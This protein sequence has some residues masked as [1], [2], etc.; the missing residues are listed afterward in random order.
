VVQVAGSSS[1][2]LTLSTA[3]VAA[4]SP[5]TLTGTVTGSSSIG[6]PVGSVD[7]YDGVNF[8]GTGVLNGSGIATFTT[9]TVPVGVHPI[10]ANY[11]GEARYLSSR[12]AAQTLTVTATGTATTL[13]SSVNP[14][15]VGQ[16]VVLTAVVA[17][18][19]GSGVPTG[20][21][22]FSEA[23]TSL[24][25]GTV[26]TTGKATLSISTLAGG[27]HAVIATYAGDANY[28]GSASA[29]LT[30]TV[31]V[32]AVAFSIS[33]TSLTIVH[34]ASGTAT[35]S[36]TPSGGFSGTATFACG[37]LPVDASCSFSP[38]SMA[39]T[40]G[41]AV[42]TTTLTIST[43]LTTGGALR[44]F[45][46]R[47]SGGGRVLALL[48]MPWL[49]L[50]G[51]AVLR[52]R[53]PERSRGKVWTMLMLVMLSAAALGGMMACGSASNTTAKGTYPIAVTISGVGATPV[54]TIQVTVQ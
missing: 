36:G 9:A 12:S 29:A 15:G 33:P 13:T 54:L 17:P 26:D 19:S 31:I 49:G 51:V 44:P 47:P 27:A 39:F 42:M 43:K 35:I 4:G 45:A 30:E 34:G 14:A 48:C 11:S 50:A 1:I 38:A 24:G 6:V 22:T 20:T 40:G 8:L 28:L 52:R 18:T 10:T 41:S 16:A 46:V 25:T 53:R 21:V 5:V 3:Q 23:G 37:T 2:A 7:F 32:P